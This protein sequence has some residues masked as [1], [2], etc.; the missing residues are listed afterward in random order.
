MTTD[1][2]LADKVVLVTRPRHQQAEFIQLLERR[3]ATAV[4]FPSIEIQPLVAD[5]RLSETLSQLNKYD[6]IIFVSANAVRFALDLLKAQ[7]ISSE[8]IS[9]PISVIGSATSAAAIAAGLKVNYQPESGFNSDALLRLPAMQQAQIASRRVLIIRGEGGLEYLAE[10][11]QKRGAEVSYAEVYRRC[12]PEKDEQ[13]TRSQLSH[14]WEDLKVNVITVTSNEALHNLCDMLESPGK[15]AMLETALI[16][17]SKRAYEL[18][19]S[20][21]FVAVTISESATNQHM[22]ESI[23]NLSHAKIED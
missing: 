12:I 11:L 5:K 8:S 21:G 1:K 9:V 7:S 15:E 10:Q 20:L 16:V 19:K 2:S 14:H 3:A 6:V 13:V 18:A 4:S 17:P 23:I 22:I